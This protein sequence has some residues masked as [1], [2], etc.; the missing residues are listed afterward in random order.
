MK[1][2]PDI[3]SCPEKDPLCNV[4]STTLT[5]HVRPAD[6]TRHAI[7]KWPPV[8][9]AYFSGLISPNAVCGQYAG[10]DYTLMWMRRH[11]FR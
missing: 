4:A 1:R 2:H 11:T 7:P 5:Y 9:L 6:L 3:L 10:R 8:P